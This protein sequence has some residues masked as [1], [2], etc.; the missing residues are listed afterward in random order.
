MT[1]Y[2]APTGGTQIALSDLDAR[3]A[4]RLRRRLVRD[5]ARAEA[6]AVRERTLATR[7]ANRAKRGEN[8]GGAQS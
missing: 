8:E 4:A 1:I 6:K 7:K 2:V 5:Q 3:A